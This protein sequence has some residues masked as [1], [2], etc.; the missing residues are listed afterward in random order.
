MKM[1]FAAVV[2]QAAAAAAGSTMQELVAQSQAKIPTIISDLQ[3]SPEELDK[4]H[5]QARM[6]GIDPADVHVAHVGYQPPVTVT[7]ADGS[8][9]TSEEPIFLPMV[10]IPVDLALGNDDDDDDEY[11]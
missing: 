2:A 3:P 4:I 8:R 6:M 9:V 5:A 11:E 10:G 1:N 7:N